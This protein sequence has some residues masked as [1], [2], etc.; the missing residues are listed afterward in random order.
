MEA[1]SE[2]LQRKG[3]LGRFPPI[4]EQAYNRW[5]IDHVVP[6]V[7]F[8]GGVSVPLWMIIPPSGWLYL[9]GGAPQSLWVASYGIVVPTLVAAVGSTFT[10]LRRWVVPIAALA[11]VVV[12]ASAL[13]LAVGIIDVGGGGAP[14]SALTFGL[15]APFMRLPAR[16]TVFL[17]VIILG[18]GI[19]LTIADM[20]NDTISSKA[21]Y[22]F[23]TA[24]SNALVVVIGIGIV[25][26]Q[27]L[28]KTFAGEQIIARQQLLIRRYAPPAV[29]DAIE[30]GNAAT[31]GAPQRRRVTALS[32]DVVGFTRIA[33][34]LDAESLA[35][36]VHEY[37]GAMVDIVERH[38][39]TVTEFAGDGVMALFGAPAER[40]P[41]AQVTAAVAA[42]TEIQ[43][44][45][46][47]LNQRW[48]KLGLDH[49][50]QTRIGINT[51]VSSV[52][53]FGSEGRGTYTAI[54]LQINIAARI[55]AKCEPGSI[56]L[57]HASW[58]LVNDTIVCEPR[59]E[60][61]VKGV[62]FPI[63][64]YTPTRTPAGPTTTNRTT[65]AA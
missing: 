35:Q 18:P 5:L 48:F 17:S 40:E 47:V 45:L 4:Q 38:G 3:M 50:L 49:E 54:G 44:A 29:A 30:I 34:A 23:I 61:E 63:K 1:V 39:G 32:S 13:W 6:L 10:S 36:I 60:T 52:G 26:E 8:V 31:V 11:L 9:P 27:L 43:A 2:D 19:G 62:H 25:G 41:E 20:L 42:A 57:S 12:T 59:G 65:P 28:R 14:V 46:P 37:M 15:L 64:L 24:Q 56:V 55:Q 22:Y 16:T 58:Q 7:R 21:G 51:G 33:D 53:T